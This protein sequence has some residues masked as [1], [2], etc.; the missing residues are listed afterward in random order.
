MI[1]AVVVF[2]LLTGVVIT[3]CG[4][5]VPF[6][7]FS[8]IFSAVGAG[9]LTTL[10]VYSKANEWIGYQ[11]VYG[12]GIGAGFQLAVIACQ[13]VLDETD[14]PRGMALIVFFQSF[15][16]AI[17]TSVG[18]SIFL[19]GLVSG[20]HKIAPTFDASVLLCSEVIDITHD[21]PPGLL[22]TV[23]ETY[24]STLSHVWYVSVALS[25]LSIIAAFG[26]EWRRIQP[27]TGLGTMHG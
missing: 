21:V 14:L 25:A 17:F 6:F 23:Q 19:N 5:Y 1:L 8:A 18:E 3:V 22:F 2:S 7:L 24:N 9:L 15:G 12:I 16:G 20:L 26:I 11:V 27:G 13:V 4:H 10:Q